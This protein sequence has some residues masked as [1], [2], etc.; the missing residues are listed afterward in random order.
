MMVTEDGEVVR[1]GDDVYLID[2]DE[3]ATITKDADQYGFINAS[4]L[5]NG[6]KVYVSLSRVASYDHTV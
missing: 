3:W 2:G 5:R 1:V 4:L 6:D